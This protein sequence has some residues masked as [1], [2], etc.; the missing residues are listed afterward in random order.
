MSDFGKIERSHEEFG[1][2]TGENLKVFEK[3][4]GHR[5][6][7]GL[8][9]CM[10]VGGLIVAIYCGMRLHSITSVMGDNVGYA[11]AFALYCT[12]LVLGI[13]VIPPAILGVF[14]ATHPKTV[15]FAIGASIVALV[16]VAAFVAYSLFIGGQLFSTALY[17]LLLVIAPILYLVCALKIKRS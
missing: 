11:L 2:G 9:I 10:F 3:T 12:G 4:W 8:S 17:A 7:M 6:L 14:T 1:V 16:L 13:G 15:N 5:V